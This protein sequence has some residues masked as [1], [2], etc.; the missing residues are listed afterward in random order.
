MALQCATGAERH[1][2]VTFRVGQFWEK[3]HPNSEAHAAECDDDLTPLL[4]KGWE[5][6]TVG[7]LSQILGLLSHQHKSNRQREQQHGSVASQRKLGIPSL[8]II[9]ASQHADSAV[10]LFLL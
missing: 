7:S 5:R 4:K 1:L 9:S 8:I 10:S 2:G 6:S 3:I